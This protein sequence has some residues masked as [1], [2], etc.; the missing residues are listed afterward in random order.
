MRVLVVVAVL[1]MN[2]C[3][4]PSET[5]AES[6]ESIARN[7]GHLAL[8]PNGCFLSI[9]YQGPTVSG[10]QAPREVGGFLDVFWE[11]SVQR[12][13]PNMSPVLLNQTVYFFGGASGLD[14]DLKDWRVAES[15]LVEFAAAHG[16]EDYADIAEAGI[17]PDRC[18][19]R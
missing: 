19:D 15:S 10:G 3:S 12:G 6:L 7:N 17:L 13:R 2:A 9:T 8:L 4:M 18:P 5:G 14:A 1:L 16:V 11:A